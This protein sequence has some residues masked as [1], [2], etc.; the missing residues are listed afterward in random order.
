M[1]YNIEIKNNIFA[2]D[3]TEVELSEKE[4]DFIYMLIAG[5]DIKKAI[6]L[7]SLSLQDLTNLYLKFG[8]TDTTKLR[9]VQLVTIFMQNK[10]D[11]KNI[12][13]KIYNN[14]NLIECKELAESLD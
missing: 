12:L 11:D 7:L 10:L 8:L 1:L 9:Y 4:L 14:Y 5:V 13:L 2:P 6:N 3:I